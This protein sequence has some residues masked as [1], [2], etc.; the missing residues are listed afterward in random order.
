MSTAGE[1][2]QQPNGQRSVLQWLRLW[3]FLRDPV[4]RREYAITGF[5]LMSFKYIVEFVAVRAMTDL[6]YT[7]L[8]FVNPL[9]SA[10]E[11][12]AHG[13]PAWFGYLWV[14]WALPFLWIAVGM[15]VRRA[16][17][18]GISP[19]HGLWVLVPFLNLPAMLIL[20]CL[21][22]ATQQATHWADEQRTREA[23]YKADDVA[24]TVKAAIGGIAIG[25]LYASVLTQAS[26]YLFHS[27]GA[28]IFFGTPL[29]TGV[30]SSYLLNAKRSHSHLASA[31][32]A[33]AAIF[34]F[35]IALML[36]AFEGA[37]CIA[38]AA[39]IVIPLGIAGAPLGKFLADRRRR[40]RRDLVSALLVLPMLT[41]AESYFPPNNEF[42]VESHID[43]AAP[44]ETVWRNVIGFA[45]ITEP[46]EW[47]F[48]LG[49]ACP[50]EARILGQ[51]VGARR[52]C[53]FTTGKFIEPITVWQE[54]AR[55]AF[56][57][58]EQPSPMFELTPYRNIHPPHLDL[59][60]RSV[61]GE[62]ELT[63]LPD[64]TTRLTGRT[65]YT[66]DIR[67]E[68]YWT[69]WSDWLV[70][71]IHMRVL[72]HIKQLAEQRGTDS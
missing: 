5:A 22:T 21:P 33:A 68:A 24:I 69:I 1:L 29:I 45:K 42:V 67:P 19:W 28:A 63:E 51:G 35:G 11:K 4:H 14:L 72:I 7:P 36:F 64:G 17:D 41:I 57:V 66:L 25:A 3:F 54:P 50:E 2:S 70:H 49:V 31:L 13:A 46:P 65:W 27:Y 59:A 52:E 53:I 38:M 40:L 55:L 12:F 37:I 43:I 8:D 18:A 61:R 32:V 48:R 23:P 39:P 6:T 30:A 56:D 20:A 15:S 44:R 71:R 26:V 9:M 62:F 16:F 47:I 10:R 58:S 34:F 60:F